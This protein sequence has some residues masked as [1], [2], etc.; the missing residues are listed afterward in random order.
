MV[1]KEHFGGFMTN[2]NHE[3]LGGQKQKS[4]KERM[5]EIIAKSKKEKVGKCTC[6]HSFVCWFP[7]LSLRGSLRLFFFLFQIVDS[8]FADFLNFPRRVYLIGFF[9]SNCWLLYQYERQAEKEK[10]REL[11][12]KLDAEWKDV[13]KLMSGSDKV[14]INNTNKMNYWQNIKS[15]VYM[16]VQCIY[17]CMW[18]IM[19][20]IKL[21]L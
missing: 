9:S 12:E 14:C 17:C 5:E 10:T 2:S 19:M 4:W 21:I 18:W 3:E 1:A 7:E 20:S 6:I 15:I 13:M 16:F 8:L 11:T